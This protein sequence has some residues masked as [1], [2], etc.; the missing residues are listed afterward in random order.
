MVDT[1]EANEEFEDEEIEE[2]SQA[3]SKEYSAA[4]EKPREGPALM[5]SVL[6]ISM[7]DGQQPKK[8]IP[9]RLPIHKSDE[10]HQFVVLATSVA[11]SI[12]VND[13]ETIPATTDRSGKAAVFTISH[14]SMYVYCFLRCEL[15]FK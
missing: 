8:G 3:K 13:W 12:D 15:V 6:D 10:G 2:Q 1:T 7:T 5:T 9:I 11:D 4:A 14:F